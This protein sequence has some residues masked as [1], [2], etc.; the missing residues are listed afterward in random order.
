MSGLSVYTYR[1]CDTCRRAVKWLESRD[2]AFVEK[3]IRETPPGLAE[4]QAMLAAQ[5][6]VVRRLFNTA[7]RDYRELRLGERLPDMT[8]AAALQLLARNGNL[9]KRPFLLGAGV[10]LVGF[11]AIVWAAALDRA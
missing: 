1:N 10:A 6:G 2:L 11:D 5:G 3:P 9:V 7:G 8:P 4:L